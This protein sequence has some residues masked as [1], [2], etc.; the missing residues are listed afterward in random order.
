MEVCI[1]CMRRRRLAIHY[2][3]TPKTQAGCRRCGEAGVIRLVVA[4]S[5][6]TCNAFES[7][8]GELKLELAGFVTTSGEPGAIV[9]LNPQPGSPEVLAQ[10]GHRLQR[11]RQVG[12]TNSRQR[13]DSIFEAG[14]LHSWFDP[15]GPAE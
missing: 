1:T 8:W 4:T 3:H 12:T 15:L 6:H 2:E 7:R 13:G 14:L 10:S 5:D 9:A 11:G